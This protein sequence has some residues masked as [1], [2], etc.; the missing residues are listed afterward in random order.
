MSRSAGSPA[1][2]AGKTTPRKSARKPAGSGAKAK[3]PAAKRPSAKRTSAK[4]RGRG[5]GS[6]RRRSAAGN[7]LWRRGGGLLAILLVCG[8]AAITLSWPEQNPQATL[9]ADSR[10]AKVAA[11]QAAAAPAKPAPVTAKATAAPAK[12]PTKTQAQTRQVEAA[13]P[14]PAPVE[15]AVAPPAAKPKAT[16]LPAWKRFSASHAAKPG[17]PKIA[18]VLDDLGPNKARSRRAAALPGPLTLAYLPYAEELPALTAAARGRGHELLIHMPMEPQ[19]LAGNNPGRNALLTSLK[20]P[21]LERRLQWALGR[22]PGYVGINNHMGS[23]FTAD[24]TGM[25]Q[26]M[27]QLSERGLLFLDSVTSAASKGTKAAKAVGVP[28]IGRDIFLDHGGDDSGLVLK[29]LAKLEALA[30]RQGY[31]IAI[32]HPHDG[33]LTALQLWIPDALARGFVLVPISALVEAPGDP[34]LRG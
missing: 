21:E 15:L 32:G 6:A 27:E 5:G 18:I 16:G 9:K 33:T 29:Q 23:A 12:T 24:L 7:R 11:T 22:F 30:K 25:T 19:N 13:A 34:G 3:R 31:A 4:R 8:L 14:E 26:V 1:K 10:P 28:T 2:G 17:Q 20:P